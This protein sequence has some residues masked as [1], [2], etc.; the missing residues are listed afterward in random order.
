MGDQKGAI[1]EYREGLALNPDSATAYFDL[2]LVLAGEGDVGNAEKHFRQAIHL[3]PNYFE[4]HLKLGQILFHRGETAHAAPHLRK[5]AE[6]PDANLRNAA[7]A[8][9][10]SK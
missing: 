7:N 9:L 2:G 5:A 10:M 6:S 3:A 4:A 8:L 1:R